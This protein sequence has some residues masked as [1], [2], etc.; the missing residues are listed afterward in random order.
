MFYIV[1]TYYILQNHAFYDHSLKQL[2]DFLFQLNICGCNILKEYSQ[3]RI[4]SKILK[5]KIL[6]SFIKL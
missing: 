1:K 4:E 5:L 2:L 6:N 3:L